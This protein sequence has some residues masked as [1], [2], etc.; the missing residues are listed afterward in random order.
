[1]PKVRFENLVYELNGMVHWQ[2]M[3]K[4]NDDL[5]IFIKKLEERTG[6]KFM[7]RKQG[8]ILHGFVTKVPK[9][10]IVSIY[11]RNKSPDKNSPHTFQAVKVTKELEKKIYGSAI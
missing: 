4:S 1:M 11:G 3:V 10:L 9:G 7:A 5:T 8:D 6:L 2:D